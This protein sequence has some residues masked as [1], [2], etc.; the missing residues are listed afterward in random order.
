MNRMQ[1][2]A[3]RALDIIQ[4]KKGKP[5]ESKEYKSRMNGFAVMVMQSG[6]A[7]ASG[8]YLGKGSG[9]QYLGYLQDLVQVVAAAE[10]GRADW[11][12][13]SFQRKV[14]ECDALTYRL[15][16]RDALAASSWL[17]RYGSAYLRD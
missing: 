8:F 5:G 12:P 10:P 3:N 7:Q 14:V 11:N 16:T 2:M 4:D 13:D 17:K 1:R 6:L 9:H 15:L